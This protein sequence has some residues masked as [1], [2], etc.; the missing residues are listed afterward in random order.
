MDGGWWAIIILFALFG[1]WGRGGFGGG[2]SGGNGCGCDGSCATVGDVQRGFDNQGVTNKLNGLE[3]GICGLGYDQL[4]QMN[5]INQNITN[6]GF[7]VQNAIQQAS[8]A[9]MQDTNAIS[10]QWLLI[11]VP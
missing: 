9:S 6:M 4:A 10:R 11:T 7:G 2:F 1:G 8:V 3:N 5:G